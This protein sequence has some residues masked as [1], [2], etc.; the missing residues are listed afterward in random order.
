MFWGLLKI[1]SMQ[2]SAVVESLH[3]Q[4]LLQTMVVNSPLHPQGTNFRMCACM[5]DCYSF[6]PFL[7]SELQPQSFLS[8]DKVSI[9]LALQDLKS[10]KSGD[11]QS[12]QRRQRL[13]RKLRLEILEDRRV[14][15][16]ELVELS[17]QFFAQNA[18]GT[19]GRNLDPDP[20][21]SVLEA[22]IAVGEKFVVRTLVKDLREP[23]PSGVF[24]VYSDL[25]YT[26]V[27]GSSVEKMQFQWGEYNSVAIGD[28]ASE[29]TFQ[30]QYGD[31]ITVDI[32][33]GTQTL[34]DGTKVLNRTETALN[35]QAAISG[36]LNV[37]LGNVSVLSVSDTLYDVTFRNA[38]ARSD[39]PDPV[40]VNNQV[41]TGGTNP[42]SVSVV[43]AGTENSNAEAANALESAINRAPD[44]S[45][46]YRYTLGGRTGSFVDLTGSVPG[47]RA[48]KWVGGFLESSSFVP[49]AIAS[50]FLA[51]N[52][53]IFVAAIAGQIELESKISEPSAD[54]N[55]NVGIAVFNSGNSSYLTSDLVILPTARI[56]IVEGILAVN[57]QTTI[58]EDSSP[59]VLNVL[60]NDLDPAGTSR[61]V[62]AVT[63]PTSGG[64][65]SI[66]FSGS[67]IIFTPSADFFGSAVSTYTVRNNLGFEAVGTVTFNV[68][69]V[70]DPPL[71]N[72]LTDLSIPKNAPAQSIALTGISA[73]PNESQFL[74]IRVTSSNPSLIPTPTVTYQSPD[75]SGTLTFAPALNQTG[76]SIVTVTVEDEGGLQAS[77]SF[78]VTVNAPPASFQNPS[79]AYDVNNDGNVSPLDILQLW[80]F[81]NSNN[82]SSPVSVL[83]SATPFYDVDGDNFVTPLDALQVTDYLNF[84]GPFSGVTGTAE[85]AIGFFTLG[86]VSLDPNPYDSMS[87][88]VVVPGQQFIVR[89]F[90]KDLRNDPKGVHSVYS[91]L[92]YTNLDGS[93]QEKIV[94]G[95]RETSNAYGNAPNG[96]LLD[97]TSANPGKRRLENLGSF[98]SDISIGPSSA[99]T[100]RHVYDILFTAQFAGEVQIS[101]SSA[102]T[103]SEKLGIA[104]FAS[105]G[106]YLPSSS[107]VFPTGKITVLAGLAA[108]NDNF[109]IVEDSVDVPLNVLENDSDDQ[110]HAISV[111]AVSQPTGGLVTIASDNLSLRFAPTLNFSGVASFT[112]TIQNSVGDQAT[113]TVTINVLPSNDPPTLD[114]IA[115]VTVLPNAPMQTIPLTGI[116]AGPGEAQPLTI[117]VT[118]SNLSLIPLPSITYFDPSETGSLQFTPSA[119]KFGS[120][121]ILVSVEDS[122]GAYTIVMFTIT[123]TA[124]SGGYQN[125][126]NPLDVNN[127]GFVSP[128]DYLAALNTINYEGPAVSVVGLSG[129]APYYDVDGD[130]FL[131]PL[132]LL[133]IA[134]FLNGVPSGSNPTPLVKMHYGFYSID[135]RNLDP[136]PGD[137]Q[138]EAIIVLGE[139]FVVRTFVQD[140]R[141]DARGVYSV[142]SDFNYVN[143]DQSTAEKM[144]Y[145]YTSS[146]QMY[147]SGI[148]NE[149][150]D[151]T[152]PTP[153][154]RVLRDVGR[155]ATKLQFP[156]EQASGSVRAYDIH[157]TA[158]ELG[159]IH[160][161]QSMSSSNNGLLGISVLGGSG[162]YLPLE[163]VV[164]P[165]GKLTIREGVGVFSATSHWVSPTA[166][167]TSNFVVDALRSG[168]V[169]AWVDFNRDGDW[170]APEDRILNRIPVTAGKNIIPF[171][172][173]ASMTLGDMNARFLLTENGADEATHNLAPGEYSKNLQIAM[174]GGSLGASIIYV[175]KL[176]AHEITIPNGLVVIKVAGNI[177]WSVPANELTKL[178]SVNRNG[179]V[180]AE[181]RDFSSAFPGV[182]LYNQESGTV[183][184]QVATDTLDLGVYGTSNL[185]GVQTIDLRQT[186]S[187]ILVLQAEDVAE[188][189]AERRLQVILNEDDALSTS[190]SWHVEP[191]RVENGVWIQPYSSVNEIT[192]IVKTLEVVS[193]R[194]WRNEVFRLDSDGNGS[195]SPLDVLLLINGV[196]NAIF[197]EGRLPPRTPDNGAG[198]YDVDGDSF[199]GPLDV[200][201]VI[202]HLN[203][204]RGGEGEQARSTDL[205]FSMLDGHA[206]TE[207][208]LARLH[209]RNPRR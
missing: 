41:T 116:S 184:L 149:S 192:G 76:T 169:D 97:L 198:F 115:D 174:E 54:P 15:A 102:S 27:D 155:F 188:I 142:Y 205:I 16:G 158:Q 18:D 19:I 48:L 209:G 182:I 105:S 37:G 74:Q 32:V 9:M 100:F 30:L 53:L 146:S 20:N 154:K 12:Q 180:I 156:P 111:V 183:E 204:A 55:Q 119:D 194:P 193:E 85:L 79:N 40:V 114:P 104:M 109:T 46:P 152:S 202:N 8:S 124:P 36:L 208:W 112:Y 175:E 87:E 106:Q 14:L 64:S 43:A 28:G 35:M 88:A 162:Q 93:A 51:A 59:V 103:E 139:Q 160:L 206:E 125:P 6:K 171:T 150:V 44:P 92:D 67:E 47:L 153:G 71:L 186:G 141:T 179:E 129:P 147:S 75:P 38:R 34:P 127:D 13:M 130:D 17:Y 50:Q 90:A 33:L 123:V 177:V 5:L 118:S 23:N 187:N 62:V 42:T 107:I 117:T 131:T 61:S 86:G 195:V 73:G 56:N 164:L 89:T 126:I 132:D 165:T 148:S 2:V 176:G 128:L 45:N 21:D 145:E 26:N 31:E 99:S 58:D 39:M 95:H 3:S 172:V 24:S 181:L 1:D 101:H 72:S 178:S 135:G 29:G 189:N 143:E 159:V 170:L 25:N 49:P 70:N 137:D 78:G 110:G 203:L 191:G 138:P 120:S 133:K 108:L 52:D 207:E 63:Q 167:T 166:P 7:A 77:Q 94:F 65:V 68:S 161:S 82:A 122:E 98:S 11:V 66:A 81:L 60:A 197:I 200:L 157:F 83:T 22:N 140:L 84:G 168:Y 96:R 10:K 144:V 69:P 151:A 57:D 199:L 134:D 185:Q 80:N 196:N 136:N 190:S 113:G 201:Q 163:Q 121:D 4:S 91:N 173:P